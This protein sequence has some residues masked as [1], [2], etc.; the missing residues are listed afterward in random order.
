M[1]KNNPKDNGGCIKAGDNKG[2]KLINLIQ[3]KVNEL[4]HV[5]CEQ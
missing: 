2:Q 1:P 5:E 3:P 4:V